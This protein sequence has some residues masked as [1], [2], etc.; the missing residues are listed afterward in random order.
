MHLWAQQFTKTFSAVPRAPTLRARSLATNPAAGLKERFRDDD[1]AFF[2]AAP[3]VAC[4]S[5]LAYASAISFLYAAS[6]CAPTAPS[7]AGRC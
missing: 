7:T 1:D 4:A 2:L 5:P 6:H 3:F